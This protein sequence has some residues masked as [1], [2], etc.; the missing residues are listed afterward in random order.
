MV[1]LGVGL[2]A[3]AKQLRGRGAVGTVMAIAKQLMVGRVTV[4]QVI[5][6]PAL[7]ELGIALLILQ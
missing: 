5:P 6:A 1:I 2:K 7:M 3:Q 4:H